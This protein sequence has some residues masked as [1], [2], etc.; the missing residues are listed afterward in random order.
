MT[1]HQG[2]VLVPTTM[3][4]TKIR[5]CWVFVTN[6]SPGVDI[7]RCSSDEILPTPKR[8]LFEVPLPIET[9]CF[10]ISHAIAR[11]VSRP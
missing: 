4:E 2:L 7:F 6:S 3:A 9:P 11:C 10:G 1:Q 8:L 5:Q